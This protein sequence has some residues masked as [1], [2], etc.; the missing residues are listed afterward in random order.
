MATP[1]N[2]PRIEPGDA[3]VCAVSA[4]VCAL[5]AVVVMGLMGWVLSLQID[6]ARGSGSGRPVFLRAMEA[7]SPDEAGDDYA[8]ADPYARPARLGPARRV[9]TDAVRE[10]RSAGVD[11]GTDRM[12]EGMR[13]IARGIA[14]GVATA[15][16]GVGLGARSA[17]A[18]LGA[19]SEGGGV[20]EG[21]YAAERGVEAVPV[22]VVH[23][24]FPTPRPPGTIRFS[25]I[26]KTNDERIRATYASVMGRTPDAR[27]LTVLGQ[28]F[29]SS[30]QGDMGRLVAV[31]AALKKGDDLDALAEEEKLA[32]VAEGRVEEA[33]AMQQGGRPSEDGVVMAVELA[34]AAPSL[35]AGG[36]SFGT[37]AALRRAVEDHRTL[38]QMLED[39]DVAV[40]PDLRDRL[41]RQ[42]MEDRRRRED[43]EFEDMH[44][45]GK[46]R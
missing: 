12:R 1:T 28:M 18:G 44:R 7:F 27:T 6:P 46:A 5:V 20:T 41:T 23:T 10:M 11:V 14:G 9:F 39:E 29:G 19:P 31:I 40:R 24:A 22:P 32:A 3:A 26:E 43:Q 8:P 21:F 37:E 45:E 25:D 16:E 2:T 15:A 33:R 4:G 38:K 34:R 35:A 36:D 42:E 13:L 17:E 30:M